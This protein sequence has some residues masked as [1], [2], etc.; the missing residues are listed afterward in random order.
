MTELPD[1]SD[2]AEN[3]GPQEYDGPS[4]SQ[5][6][7]DSQA[8]QNMGKKLVEMPSGQLEKFNLPEA[9]E[10]AIQEARRLKSR[11]AKRRHLQYIGKLMR[12]LDIST[13]QETLER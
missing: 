8:L 3:S 7:R 6:K 10:Q 11:E 1:Q 9:L 12:T 13:I 4:K 2:L 5:L